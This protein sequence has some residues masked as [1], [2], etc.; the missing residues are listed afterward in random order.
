MTMYQ[1][2]NNGHVWILKSL[3]LGKKICSKFTWASSSSILYYHRWKGP[4]NTRH[5]PSLLNLKTYFYTTIDNICMTQLSLIDKTSNYFL[6]PGVEAETVTSCYRPEIP[7]HSVLN[8]DK[9][10]YLSGDAVSYDCDTGG[11]SIKLESR[12]RTCVNGT[13]TGTTPR[14]LCESYHYHD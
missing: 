5:S 11:L 7:V 12:I 3:E 9:M 4:P 10:I 1:N 6:C 14:C 13:W 2:L 8:P